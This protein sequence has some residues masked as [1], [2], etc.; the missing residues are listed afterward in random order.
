MAVKTHTYPKHTHTPI[1]N[2]VP[3]RYS[4]HELSK[5]WE[6]SS[7]WPPSIS[8]VLS[9]PPPSV[10]LH[11]SNS[12]CLGLIFPP[13]LVRLCLLISNLTQESQKSLFQHFL[14][15]LLPLSV[16][17]TPPHL[18]SLFSDT[19]S[20]CASA[21]REWNTNSQPTSDSK[22]KATGRGHP[23]TAH[24]HRDFP[25]VCAGVCSVFMPVFLHACVC[26]AAHRCVCLCLYTG[27]CLSGCAFHTDLCISVCIYLSLQVCACAS[28]CV[29]LYTL[30]VKWPPP[31]AGRQQSTATWIYA[32]LWTHTRPLKLHTCILIIW[33]HTYLVTNQRRILFFP[34]T[35]DK[36]MKYSPMQNRYCVFFIVSQVPLIPS[37]PPGSL[38]VLKLVWVS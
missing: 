28:M 9:S 8:L 35:E 14:S 36:N 7:I 5:V 33:A 25:A 4:S 29:H 11:P 27:V 21:L 38:T 23:P 13:K 15:V 2:R 10:F 17:L 19:A 12:L 26:V 24:R 3:Q 32:D 20:L 22:P 16:D 37:P 30:P 1:R 6:Q 34:P 18:I 31:G